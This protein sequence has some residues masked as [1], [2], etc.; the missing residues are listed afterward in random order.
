MDLLYFLDFLREAI[1]ANQIAVL[2][3]EASIKPDE[4]VIVE[5]LPLVIVV[6]V[7]G[8]VGER[9]ERFDGMELIVYAVVVFDEIVVLPGLFLVFLVLVSGDE[10]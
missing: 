3:D 8:G 7:V 4:F 9:G 5:M 1:L 10:L 2:H 6:L